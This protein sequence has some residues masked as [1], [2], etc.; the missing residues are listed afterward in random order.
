MQI[1]VLGDIHANARSLRA[2]LE[3][4]DSRGYDQLIFLGDLLTYGVDI[5]ETIDLVA[6]RLKDPF[7]TLLRGNHDALYDDLL[8]GK[9][10]Y[11]DLLPTWIKESV[12]WTFN[13]LQ[14]K[15]WHDLNFKDELVIQKFLFSHANPFGLGR[16]D[17][18]NTLAEHEKAVDVLKKRELNVGVFGHTH[19]AKWYRHID[20]SGFFELN[21][22]G[23]LDF[24]ACH[25][26]NAG[27]IGQSREK[28]NL[29]AS[30]L[31]VNIPND[32][33][34]IPTFEQQD[35][36]WDVLGHL[37]GLAS[38]GLSSKTLIRL[39]NFFNFYDA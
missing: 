35:Y 24:P 1:A 5:D 12:E 33:K 6:N 37:Q 13:R 28:E 25:I 21:K 30:V 31:L 16:W 18:L 32:F 14:Q 39:S 23:L 7:T 38:S 2:A 29:C 20:N 17:Y 19:R 11:Y 9:I 26:L 3:I 8:I 4:I 10:T 34:M 27:S 22:S 15:I 36:S